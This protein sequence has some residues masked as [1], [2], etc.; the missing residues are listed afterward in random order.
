M[1]S[2]GVVKSTTTLTSELVGIPPSTIGHR[3][4]SAIANIGDLDGDGITDLAV[5]AAGIVRGG[6]VTGDLYILFMNPDG[7][8]RDTAEINSE[9]PNAPQLGPGDVFGE[10]VASLGDLDGDGITELAV[11]APGQIIG[12]Q[13]TGDLYVLF[14]NP[15]GTVKLSLIHISEPTRPY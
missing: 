3:F 11:G 2:G 13:S 14:M 5:G 7:T 1:G 10:E 9:T 15:D 12:G 4:G 6:N 8:V